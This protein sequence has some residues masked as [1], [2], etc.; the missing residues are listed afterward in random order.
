MDVRMM[1]ERRAPG[2]EDGGQP[3]TAECPGRRRSSTAWLGGSPD[4]E[5]AEQQLVRN[6]IAPIARRH[7][8]DVWGPAEFR[9][10]ARRSLPRRAWHFRAV[11]VAG[12]VGGGDA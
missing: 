10:R 3:G 7:P 8:G 5:V 6:A 2:V 9:P 4:G 1:G 11:A 12:Q